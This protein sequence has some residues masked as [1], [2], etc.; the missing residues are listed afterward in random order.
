MGVAGRRRFEMKAIA[1]LMMEHRLIEKMI[2]TVKSRIPA[3]MRTQTV[4]TDFID[5]TIDFIKTYADQVHHGKEEDILFRECTLKAMSEDDAEMMQ[6]LTDEHIDLR[7][8]VSELQQVNQGLR[9]GREAVETMVEKLNA[10]VAFYPAHIEMED[11][12]FFPN[13]EKYFSEVE[14]KRLFEEF[15]E[16]DRTLIH[17]KYRLIVENLK[18]P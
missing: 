2:D 14:Q 15:S 18:N 8:V 4:N 17:E 11:R 3:L 12:H 1:M 6:K 13:S 9:N 16:F 5:T 10:L 7:M